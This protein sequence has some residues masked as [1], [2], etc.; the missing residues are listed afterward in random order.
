MA[1]LFSRRRNASGFT[2]VELLVVIAI[3]GVLI[4]LLLPAVQQARE[5]A[6]R[7]Q[8]SNNMKQ[9]GLGMHN[10]HDTFKVFPHGMNGT[11]QNA[12]LDAPLE[13]SWMPLILP[14]IEQ[15]NLHDSFNFNIKTS[16]CCGAW[17]EYTA[18]VP[19]LLCPSDPAGV[20]N[21][22]QGFHGNYVMCN[23]DTTFN[24]AG[25]ADG[26]KRNGMFFARSKITF[27]SVIDGTSNTILASEL[28]INPDTSSHDLRGRYYNGREGSTFFTTLFPPN[29]SIG[30]THIYCINKLPSLPC[31]AGSE[32]K[33]SARSQHPGGVM[34]ALADASVTFAPET[35]DLDTWHRLGARNDGLVVGPF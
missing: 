28:L 18:V 34:I 30:D 2:L 14:F 4:A 20:K 33:L 11:I 31:T 7:M 27:A 25:D 21:S 32:Y 29:T 22:Q 15:K 8:C 3:I 5:A 23:G 12:G 26:V 19:T 9:L 13:M 17:P 10:Y 1:S 35:V 16:T 6:R 24:P